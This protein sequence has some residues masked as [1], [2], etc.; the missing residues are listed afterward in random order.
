MGENNWDAIIRG[1]FGTG[2][3]TTTFAEITDGTSNT[4]AFGERCI[5]AGPWN[6]ASGGDAKARVSAPWGWGDAPILCLNRKAAGNQLGAF[7]SNNMAGRRWTDGRS[8]MSGFCTI[9]APNSPSCMPVIDQDWNWGLY[10]G[11]SY[12]PGGCNVALCDGSVR[13][14]SETIDT[15]RVDLSPLAS[16]SNLP[17]PYGVWGALGSKNGGESRSNF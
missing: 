8:S 7:A 2:G 3:R 1:A 5:G 12:H 10:T 17:S 6:Q 9:L 15:G 4:I 14:I 13:F 11:G 16:N